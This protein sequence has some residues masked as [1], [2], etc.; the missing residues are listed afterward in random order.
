[1]QSSEVPYAQ[2]T[3]FRVL[4]GNWVR[5]P[6]DEARLGPVGLVSVHVL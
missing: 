1:M 3:G 4:Q 6:H 5:E 2:S